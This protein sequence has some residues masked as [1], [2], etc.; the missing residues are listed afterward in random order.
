MGVGGPVRRLCNKTE[1]LGQDMAGGGDRWSDG[2]T[3]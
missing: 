2:G 1:H 3:L